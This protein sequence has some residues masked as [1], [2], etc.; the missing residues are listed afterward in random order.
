M[1]E[2]LKIEILNSFHLSEVLKS[3]N[4]LGYDLLYKSDKFVT[5]SI[6]NI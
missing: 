5:N 3:L 6:K 4:A 2:N 1:F